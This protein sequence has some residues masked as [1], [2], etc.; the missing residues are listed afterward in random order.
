MG[1]QL[2]Q[3]HEIA[4]SSAYQARIAAAM[5]MN[6]AMAA[7]DKVSA[8][9][10]KPESMGLDSLL[11]EEVWAGQATVRSLLHAYDNIHFQY[12]NGFLDQESWTRTRADI[13]NLFRLL[14]VREY[15]KTRLFSLRISFRI[16]VET[17][18]AEVESQKGD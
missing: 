15:V 5:E 4:S 1:L 7:N 3:S 11:P 14:F 13:G 18:L 2:K 16:E 8:A 17:I 9:F 10:Y 12:E 6:S